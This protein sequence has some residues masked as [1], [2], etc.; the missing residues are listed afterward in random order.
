[1]KIKSSKKLSKET[2][3]SVKKGL[4]QS[5]NNQVQYLESFKKYI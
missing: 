2:L 5:N 3:K 4:E 1:M